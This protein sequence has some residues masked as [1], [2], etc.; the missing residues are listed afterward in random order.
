MT[1]DFIKTYW[2][3][4]K[5]CDDGIQ[6]FKDNIR[7]ATPGKIGY[8]ESS[9]VDHSTKQSMDIHCYPKVFP[10]YF[11]QYFDELLPCV[12]QYIEDYPI[13]KQ[14]SFGST[15]SFKIQWYKP[16]EAFFGAHAERMVPDTCTR[17]L[18]F[19]TFF[20][21]VEEGGETEFIYQNKKFKPEKG[22]TLI[23]SSEW[24]HTHRGLPAPNEEKYIATGWLNILPIG[25]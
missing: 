3:S 5:L 1:D 2:L 9:F 10:E 7:L 6:L 19:M 18:T 24:M 15:E 21:T 20:N 11:E 22:K 4:E 17:L 16:G 25:Y 8:R 14:I 23:W 13:L 12:K